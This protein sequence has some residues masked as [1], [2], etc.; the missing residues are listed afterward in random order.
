MKV[1]ILFFASLK[2]AAGCPRLILDIPEGT[3]TAA[4]KEVLTASYP[5][6]QPLLNRCITAIN[7][8]FA[9][10]KENIPPD[11]EVAFFPPVSGGTDSPTLV[12]VTYEPLDLNALT[13]AITQPT[14]GAVCCFTG[15]VRGITRR[16][17]KTTLHLEYEAYIPMAEEKLAQI[18]G[19]IR[20]RWTTIQGIAIVQRIGTLQPGEPSVAVLCAAEH[21][22][23]GVFEAARYGIDRL[24]QVVPIWK[25]ECGANGES[26]I[27]GNYIP[28]ED[29]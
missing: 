6:L 15:I 26:W 5:Q 19:E 28:H 24:K 12:K 21:R 1:T 25:K 9:S 17:N 7:H 16:E 11:A 4:L 29:E 14:T 27:E 18:A 13:A 20:Q 22:D 2:D 10:A 23:T 8:K 3:S